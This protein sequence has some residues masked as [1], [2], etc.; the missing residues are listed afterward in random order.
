MS[1]LPTEEDVLAC[2]V[3]CAVVNEG[4]RDYALEEMFRCWPGDDPLAERVMPDLVLRC[5]RLRKSVCGGWVAAIADAERKW[6]I[7]QAEREVISAAERWWPAQH[8]PFADQ[9]RLIGAITHLREVRLGS[10]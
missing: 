2:A 3:V 10:R 1:A 5:A 4:P 6:E 7:E 9:R 8:V